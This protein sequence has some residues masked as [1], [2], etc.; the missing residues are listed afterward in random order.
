M[1]FK[2]RRTFLKNSFLTSVIFV[3][4]YNEL[5]AAVTPM[6][7]IALVHKDL[8]PDGRGVPKTND[9]NASYYLNA[10]LNHSR[11]SDEMKAFI[12]DGVKRLNEE[13]AA[14]YEKVYTRLTASQREKILE[15]IADTGW[16]ESWIETL[17]T[18]LLEAML[19]DPV[20][21]GNR[22]AR[23]WIWLNH[24]PGLPTPVKALL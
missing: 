3:T 20:Y 8:F 2:T 11:V 23:G 12:R 22:A 6:D 4:C 21:G 17:L 24:K 9:I 16:G 5:F 14:Q 15:E 18:Y 10:I 7:T 13:S 19:G 1:I